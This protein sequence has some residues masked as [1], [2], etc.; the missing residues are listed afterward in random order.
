MLKEPAAPLHFSKMC[1]VIQQICNP[2]VTPNLP[3]PQPLSPLL[4]SISAPNRV[5]PN[6][7]MWTVMEWDKAQKKKLQHRSSS[8]PPPSLPAASTSAPEEPDPNINA[9]KAIRVE[10][11]LLGTLK[12]PAESYWGIQTLRAVSN[13]QITGIPVSYYPEFVVAFAMV[14]KAAA[15]ANKK[16]GTLDDSI[17][18]AIS[19]ACDEIISGR[20]HDEFLVD[21]IQGGAGTSTNM[22]ANEVIANRALELLGK[23]KGAYVNC[24]PNDHVNKSQSTNDSYPTACKLAIL[25]KQKALCTEMRALVYSL[26]AKA[27]EFRT[28]LKMGRTSEPN[29]MFWVHSRANT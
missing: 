29:S 1:E 16:V 27:S 26:R 23:P 20:L 19:T 25:L 24:H 2:N 5:A 17:A 28:V 21:M 6:I 8:P 4:Q 13:Y 12:I 14:K 3:P 15:A 7:D 18:T 11:D 10:S 9:D 22:N